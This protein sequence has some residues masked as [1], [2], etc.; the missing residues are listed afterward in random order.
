VPDAV[1]LLLLML[2]PP[3]HSQVV[4]HPGILGILDNWEFYEY[5][6]LFQH[7]GSYGTDV[8]NYQLAA[9][10][11][12][13]NMSNPLL[14]ENGAIRCVCATQWYYVGCRGQ[15]WDLLSAVTQAG[16]LLHAHLHLSHESALHVWSRS[17][18]KKS[19]FC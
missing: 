12:T 11:V 2:P 1:L 14:S 4:S 6:Q 10:Q 8:L 15:I 9:R 5:Y 17:K 7:G 16:Q 13:L 3:T 19:V 18:V